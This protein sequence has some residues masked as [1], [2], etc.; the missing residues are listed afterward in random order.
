[1]PKESSLSLKILKEFVRDGRVGKAGVLIYTVD[2]LA[3]IMDEITPQIIQMPLNI[4]SKINLTR[5]A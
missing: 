2:T 5:M 1:M 3:R 4:R